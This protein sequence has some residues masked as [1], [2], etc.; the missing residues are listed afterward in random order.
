MNDLSNLLIINNNKY[1]NLR[2]NKTNIKMRHS[3]LMVAKY[4]IFVF[5]INNTLF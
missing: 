4:K 2:L 5:R 1:C 3:K